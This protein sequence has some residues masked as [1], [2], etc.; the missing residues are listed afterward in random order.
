MNF[1]LKLLPFFFKTDIV[2][3]IYAFILYGFWKTTSWVRFCLHAV[4][5]KIQTPT[6]NAKALVV[7]FQWSFWL[8]LK[9][10][11]KSK[12]VAINMKHML[13][14]K[15]FFLFLGFI[16]GNWFQSV[17]FMFSVLLLRGCIGYEMLKNL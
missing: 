10:I 15:N 14:N 17:L 3:P 7:F 2:N 5:R 13:K 6:F 11:T 16:M 9:T 8:L 4:W 1:H 12:K